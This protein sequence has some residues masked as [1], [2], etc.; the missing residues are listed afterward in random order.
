VRE[1]FKRHTDLIEPLSLDEAYLD[2]TE[3]KTGL[4]TA[5]L[6][7]RTI[8]EQIRQEL[9]LTASA[10]VATNKFL[11]KLASD[12]RKPDG[13]FVI[14]PAEV[15]AFLS[16]LPVGRLPGVG[17]VTGEK[18]ATLKIQTVGDLR[19]LDSQVLEQHF[20]RYGLRL[21]ELARGIDDNEVI[22]DR[23]TQ[24]ISIEDTFEHDV[25]FT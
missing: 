3:N 24:S 12:W 19:R 9:N 8:R 4:P 20:G 15:D 14:Q 11:A 7:A 1:I 6:V 23:P 16:P 5:T 10:G 25:P 21:H 2:V 13:L 17:R 18:L 22:P